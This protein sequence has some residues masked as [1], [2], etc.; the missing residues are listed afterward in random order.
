MT[1]QASPTQDPLAQLHDIH[2]PDPVSLWPP[3]VGWWIVI[4]LA[5]IAAFFIVRQALIIWRNG[6]YKREAFKLLKQVDAQFAGETLNS[7]GLLAIT[8]IMKRVSIKR[9]PNASVQRL[10]GNAWLKF[11]DTKGNT[12]QFSNGPGEVLGD[13]LFKQT[14]VAE[15]K[16]LTA[17]TKRWIKQQ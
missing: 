11:L 3:A 2:L 6:R 1:P 10:T 12:N 17:L 13:A 8:H 15:K 5:L 9:Y 7:E 4:L 14:T 16:P